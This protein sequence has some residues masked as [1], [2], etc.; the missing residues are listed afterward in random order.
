MPCPSI[1]PVKVWPSEG[2]LE[3]RSCHSVSSYGPHGT[4]NKILTQTLVCKVL[5]NPALLSLTGSCPSTLLRA[6][7]SNPTG[8][9]P[10]LQTGQAQSQLSGRSVILPQ[11]ITKLPPSHQT[12]LSTGVP[13]EG[14]IPKQAPPQ[15]QARHHCNTLSCPQLHSI[16]RL[17]VAYC[18]PL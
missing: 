3:P 4:C 5:K 17:E 2:Y 7:H 6:P 14:G 11:I 15:V 8:L 13:P 12:G 10:A 18:V 16:P 1:S 9:L